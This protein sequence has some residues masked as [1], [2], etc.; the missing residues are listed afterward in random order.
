MFKLN[1]NFAYIFVALLALSNAASAQNL[2]VSDWYKSNYSQSRAHVLSADGQSIKLA[3]EIKIIE[4]YKTYW[5]SPGSTG[6]P[7]LVT[8]N[9]VNIVADS[10]N[11]RF[12]YPHRYINK[13]GETWGYKDKVV[14]FV[15][16]K[17][18]NETNESTID[19][20]FDYAVCD[21]I[22]LPEHAEF[23]LKLNANMLAKTMS[24]IKF[25]KYAKHIAVKVPPAKSV[26]TNAKLNE[27]NQLVLTLK[28]PLSELVY[29]T[30]SNNR[31]YQHVSTNTDTQIYK[32]LGRPIDDEYKT[33][34]LMIH[35]N[36]GTQYFSTEIQVN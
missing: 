3:V 13:Y 30:D 19:F 1:V 25:S 31:F 26:F 18:D 16:V 20:T 8:I 22:C 11:I 15:D 7:P 9:G 24:A 4:N 17:R 10:A 28:S 36:D 34:K 2:L 27:S 14:L 6:V 23:K 33:S 12:P 32:P 5:K 35:Y 29:V 21:E